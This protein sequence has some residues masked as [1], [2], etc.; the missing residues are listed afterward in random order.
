MSSLLY[1]AEVNFSLHVTSSLSCSK[2]SELLCSDLCFLLHVLCDL[3]N[4]S[5]LESTFFLLHFFYYSI[6]LSALPLVSCVFAEGR[7][8]INLSFLISFIEIFATQQFAAKFELSLLNTRTFLGLSFAGRDGFIA[9]DSGGAGC[10][11]RKAQE[12]KLYFD[13]HDHGSHA[14]VRRGYGAGL[15]GSPRVECSTIVSSE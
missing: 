6:S 7:K 12:R 8:N 14:F 2:R 1:T 4:S 10:K 5:F 15:P 9:E 3:F 11:N 13:T